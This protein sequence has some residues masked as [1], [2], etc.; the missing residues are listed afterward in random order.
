MEG[1]GEKAMSDDLTPKEL[2]DLSAKLKEEFEKEIFSGLSGTP[3]NTTP[4]RP[5]AANSEPL[6]IDQLTKM[7]N[8]LDALLAD[9]PKQPPI[10]WSMAN[11][12]TY[13]HFFVSNDL[14]DRIHEATTGIHIASI[15]PPEQGWPIAMYCPICKVTTFILSSWAAK[16]EDGGYFK[17]KDVCTLGDHAMRLAMKTLEFKPLDPYAYRPLP[18][19]YVDNTGVHR[20]VPP[21]EQDAMQVY[22]LH[23]HLFGPYDAEIVQ[24]M[25]IEEAKKRY[26]DAKIDAINRIAQSEEDAGLYDKVLLPEENKDK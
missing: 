16:P 1:K 8:D 9:V 11:K 12:N 10:E 26:P 20:G 13:D 23:R 21:T 15:T 3:I 25:T 7:K 24:E 4:Y 2:D 19:G 17:I 18:G 6:T 22:M 5:T 14:L